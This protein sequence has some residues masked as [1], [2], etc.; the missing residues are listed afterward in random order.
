FSLATRPWQGKLRNMKSKMATICIVC[1][2]I[3][4]GAKLI[5]PMSVYCTLTRYK[6]WMLQ[7][8]IHSIAFPLHFYADNP[9]PRQ[10]VMLCIHNSDVLCSDIPL[11]GAPLMHN[12]HI[13]SFTCS[14]WCD[15]HSHNNCSI[16]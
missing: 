5:A 9:V 6:K 12:F 13:L 8:V 14:G 11:L 1:H 3:V 16:I 4:D 7:S 2:D 10:G 15:V